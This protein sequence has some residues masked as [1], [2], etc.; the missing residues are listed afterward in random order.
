MYYEQLLEIENTNL[1]PLLHCSAADN[2][3]WYSVPKSK[4]I[5]QSQ[6][7]ITCNWIELSARKN[8]SAGIYWS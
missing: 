4:S 5:P 7:E 2:D 1:L 6:D 8:F 3:V